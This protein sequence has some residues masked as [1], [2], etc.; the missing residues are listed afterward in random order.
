[1]SR[2]NRYSGNPRQKL[3]IFRLITWVHLLSNKANK[4]NDGG[5]D[6]R[7]LYG[8][9]CVQRDFF[10]EALYHQP[11]HESQGSGCAQSY[12]GKLYFPEC[13]PKLGRFS[14]RISAQGVAKADISILASIQTGQNVYKQPGA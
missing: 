13:T 5:A 1:M 10:W 2:H 6:S 9:T 8:C 14:L 7:G 12:A 4:K 11:S 3:C